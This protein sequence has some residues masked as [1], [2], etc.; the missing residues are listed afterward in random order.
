MCVYPFPRGGEDP[1]L[2]D[3]Q[4]LPKFICPKVFIIV[5]E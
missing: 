3:E 5:L 2:M 4:P 1:F